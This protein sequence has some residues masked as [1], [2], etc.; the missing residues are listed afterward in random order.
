[1]VAAEEVTS[2]LRTAP[3]SAAMTGFC[4][5]AAMMSRARGSACS[6]PTSERMSLRP[7]NIRPSPSTACPTS[8]ATLRR[9][10]K[11]TVKP[12]PTSTSA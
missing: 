7:R 9:A 10:T 6:T 12:R 2:A 1:M 8:F 5:T 4:A 3:A 11:P